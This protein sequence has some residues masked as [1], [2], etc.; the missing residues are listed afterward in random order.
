M[1]NKW[2]NVYKA[3]DTLFEIEDGLWLEVKEMGER[4]EKKKETKE[5]E[6]LNNW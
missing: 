2:D 6:I 1:T 5:E 4:M 3:Y